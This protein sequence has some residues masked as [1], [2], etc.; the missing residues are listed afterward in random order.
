MSG[1]VLVT[2][3]SGF[4]GRQAVE[5]LAAM[6][7][8]VHAVART[9]LDDSSATWPSATWHRA[10]LL[11]PAQ[12]RALLDAARPS[13]LLHLAWETRPGR[14]WQA[15][16]NRT[17]VEATLELLDAFDD[18][19]GRRAVFAGSCAE[20]DWSPAAHGNG[21]CR[22]DATPCR[23]ATPYGRAK[24]AAFERTASE[25]AQRGISH[26]WGRL[27]LLYGPFEAEARLVPSVIHS[28]LAFERVAKQ[29]DVAK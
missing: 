5:A 6:E 28:L 17:W 13:H 29:T 26:A 22:E 3:A 1:V 21:T 27:F 24:L 16:E 14:F 18:A 2:G 4:V 20:Y 10:D 8:D 19:G 23:P 15:P 9:P 25:A 11:D 7:F 12:R